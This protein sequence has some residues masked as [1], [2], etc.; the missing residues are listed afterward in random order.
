M[1]HSICALWA[2]VSLLLQQFP[3]AYGATGT[4]SALNTAQGASVGVTFDTVLNPVSSL[5]TSSY[6]LDGTNAVI[7]SVAKGPDDHTVV[8]RFSGYFQ[9]FSTFRLW[10][11]N[12]IFAVGETGGSLS[13]TG[14]VQPVYYTITNLAFLEGRPAALG[15]F[16]PRDKI[17]QVGTVSD[18]NASKGSLFF[19]GFPLLFSWVQAGITNLEEGTSVAFLYAEGAAATNRYVGLLVT[20]IGADPDLVRLELRYGDGTNVTSWPGSA[21]ITNRLS[22]IQYFMVSRSFN[23]FSASFLPTNTYMSVSLGQIKPI[24]WLADRA[25]GGFA[26]GGTL[27]A[28]S[29]STGV[30]FTEPSVG[31]Y[32]ISGGV[33]IARVQ[34]PSPGFKVS[35]PP[36]SY[37]LYL[38][39]S[40]TLRPGNWT[41][42]QSALDDDSFSFFI[43]A[44]DGPA[45]FFR[46][47][48]PTN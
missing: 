24:P 5:L 9:S 1:K 2:M 30:R 41:R 38:E 3:L 34:S 47:A 22:A 42:V 13:I 18:V 40:P 35:V 25:L 44:S 16:A 7:S 29:G 46:L 14:K 12:S 37:S 31:H 23:R 20:R 15:A 26:V 48:T 43:P 33:S 27:P 17:V 21:T 10:V 39:Q 45:G 4:A 28:T 36:S 19:G 8:I 11:T 6:A 32:D